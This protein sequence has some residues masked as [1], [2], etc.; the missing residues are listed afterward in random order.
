MSI[1]VSAPGKLMILGEHAVLYGYPCIATALSKYLFVEAITDISKDVLFTPGISNQSFLRSALTIFRQNY[2]IKKYIN[3][4]TRSELGNYGLGSSAATIVGALK[5]LSRLFNIPLS[6]KELFDLAYEIAITVQ[7]KASGFDLACAI[8]GG[9]IYF[10][11][12]TKKVE[13]IST[14]SLPMI[15]AFSGQKRNTVDMVGYV[16]QL[17]Q[18]K[19]HFIEEIFRSIALLVEE[20][21]KAILNCNW[22][23]LGNLLNKNQEFLVK[24]KISTQ[25][26]DQMIDAARKAGSFGAKLSGAG[27]GDCMIALVS[28]EKKSQVIQ[29]VKK[30]GGEVLDLITSVEG[31]SV[32]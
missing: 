31:V 24:L 19:P 16:E 17:K 26:L 20:G 4:K 29:A 3:I 2:G 12:R 13:K 6:D 7:K 18:E 14:L 30:V 9:T 5:A 22:K 11:G 21:K 32:L 27:G 1:T 25:K 28:L 15:A 10:D 8:Y 23:T